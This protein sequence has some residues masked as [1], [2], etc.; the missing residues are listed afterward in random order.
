MPRISCR[1]IPCAW[2]ILSSGLSLGQYPLLW[3]NVTLW[4][5]SLDVRKELSIQNDRTKSDN[6]IEVMLLIGIAENN[7]PHIVKWESTKPPYAETHIRWC[8]RSVNVKI[9]GKCLLGL[10]F[11]S[12][13]IFYV[14]YFADTVVFEA[15]VAWTSYPAGITAF[16]PGM[17]IHGQ[18]KIP[19]TT[20]SGVRF[21][22][23]IRTSVF[24]KNTGV[25]WWQIHATDI[26]CKSSFGSCQWTF[27]RFSYLSFY[28]VSAR[29]Y[30]LA[31]YH[32]VL[33]YPKVNGLSLLNICSF[34]LAYWLQWYNGTCLDDFFL[35]C[36]SKLCTKQWSNDKWENLFHR[37]TILM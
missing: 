15:T 36:K 26:Y 3:R 19:V 30:T 11:T 37:L 14:Y 9:G 5:T 21:L 20:A 31:I 25:S 6:R 10:A 22:P 23:F 13:P 4:D 18:R 29:Y 32:N 16:E 2:N 17:K 28:Q 12:Y 33:C 27:A 1:P 8:G 24:V 7:L 35:L 34:D